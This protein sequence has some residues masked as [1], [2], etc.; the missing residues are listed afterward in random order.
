MNLTSETGFWRGR[1]VLVTGCTGLVGAWTTRA[2]VARGAHVVG[3]VRDKVAGTDLQRGG[4]WR[5]IDR[6]HGRLEN[7]ALVERVVNE[8]EI[9]PSVPPCPPSR[10]TFA[11]RIICWRRRDAA[12]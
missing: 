9:Q 4:L 12:A 2:L 6:V 8:Y 5:K 1:R 10:P 7:M 11:A 3:L